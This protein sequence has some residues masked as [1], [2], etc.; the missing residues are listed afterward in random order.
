MSADTPKF[1][2]GSV[3]YFNAVPLRAKILFARIPGRV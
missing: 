1:R 3:R 2:I